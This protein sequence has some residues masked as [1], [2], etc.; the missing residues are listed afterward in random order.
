MTFRFSR[1]AIFALALGGCNL[2]QR[3]PPE[4][5]NTPELP[6]AT[7]D[8]FDTLMVDK[9]GTLTEG[10][11]SLVSIKVAPEEEPQRLLMFAAS[12]NSR[13]HIEHTAHPLGPQLRG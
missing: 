13:S 10:K 3:K 2:I 7:D 8:A 6:T 5:I 11:P 4:P 12:Q 9:T 1:I